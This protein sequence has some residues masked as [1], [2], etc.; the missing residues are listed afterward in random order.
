MSSNDESSTTHLEPRYQLRSNP[1]P[2]EPIFLSSRSSRRYHQASTASS[3]SSTTPVRNSG[4]GYTTSTVH[5]NP[6]GGVNQWGTPVV[7]PAFT[8]SSYIPL[9]AMTST[10]TYTMEVNSSSGRIDKFSGR[11][12]TISLREFKATFSTVVCELELKYGANY[13]EAFDVYEQHS[14]RILGVTQIPNPAYAI[15]IATASQAALQ[16][17]IAHHG[18]VPN[19]PDPV[20]TSVNLSPQQLIAATANIPPTTDAP[21]FVDPVGEFFRIL[22]LEFPVKSSEKN[23]TTRH[24]LAVEG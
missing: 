10:P 21:T 8:P 6:F 14:P 11:P 3:S 20:P 9:Q 19:N 22:E 17:T 23:L 2:F 24:L 1:Q 5:Q 16:A 15:A 12:S 4:S 13:T 18:T 7:A